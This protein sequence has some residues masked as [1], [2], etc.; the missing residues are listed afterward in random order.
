AWSHPNETYSTRVDTL[1]HGS[2]GAPLL[3][4]TMFHP[5]GAANTLTG[6]A[7]LDLFYGVKATDQS[8]ADGEIFVEPGQFNAT[9][10]IAIGDLSMTHVYLD[11]ETVAEVRLNTR[12]NWQFSLPVGR[13]TLS[14]ANRAATV[15]FQ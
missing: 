7:G 12:S 4:A 10:T 13:H 11:G 8:D 15:A 6:G 1:L 14:D 9:T 2:G 5:N 3:G